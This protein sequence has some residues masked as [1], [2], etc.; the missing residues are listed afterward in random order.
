MIHKLT[1]LYRSSDIWENSEKSPWPD[2]H[3]IKTKHGVGIF[4]MPGL[5][6]KGC[7]LNAMELFHGG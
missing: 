3:D 1:G 5:V 2:H 6:E 7:S 4:G